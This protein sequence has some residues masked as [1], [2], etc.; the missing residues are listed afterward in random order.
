MPAADDLRGRLEELQAVLGRVVADPAALGIRPELHE[1]LREA[2]SEVRDAFV[3]TF[4]FL[5]GDEPHIELATVGLTGSELALKLAG[6][7]LALADLEAAAQGLSIRRIVKALK[8]L[9]DW[10][11]VCLDSLAKL[12]NQADRIA[13]IKDAVGAALP[14]EDDLPDEEDTT[15]TA[16]GG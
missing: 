7:D 1:P 6:F 10:A 16:E 4:E 8:K 11:D 13:E 12:L 2:W 3:D 14:D 5:H 15:D 9:F